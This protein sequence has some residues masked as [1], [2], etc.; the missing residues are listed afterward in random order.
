MI[1]QEFTDPAAAGRELLPASRLH[2]LDHLEDARCGTCPAVFEGRVSGQHPQSM[3]EVGPRQLLA[4]LLVVLEPVMG[5]GAG[6]PFAPWSNGRGM[7]GRNGFSLAVFLAQIKAIRF[8]IPGAV[9]RREGMVPAEI[10]AVQ[11][12]PM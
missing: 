1:E 7:H 11:L 10:D 6:N 8:P 2:P 3:H 4:R 12:R 9:D 5:P